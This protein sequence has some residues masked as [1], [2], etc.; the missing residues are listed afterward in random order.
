MPAVDEIDAER[1]QVQVFRTVIDR[2][3]VAGG[4]KQIVIDLIPER[5][6]HTHVA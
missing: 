5:E 2:H 6:P 3:G 1:T 4:Q